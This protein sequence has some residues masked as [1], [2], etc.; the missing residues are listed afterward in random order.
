[1]TLAGTESVAL[2]VLAAVLA[3]YLMVALVDPERF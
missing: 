3:V 1:M 2:L